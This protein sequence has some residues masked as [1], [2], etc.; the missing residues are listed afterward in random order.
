[1]RKTLGLVI[2]IG[3]LVLAGC[4]TTGSGDGLVYDVD[5]LKVAL[6]ENYAKQNNLQVIWI[7]YP[8]RATAASK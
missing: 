7:N 2:A 4:A 3:S 8:Q 5:H 1:M 6:V